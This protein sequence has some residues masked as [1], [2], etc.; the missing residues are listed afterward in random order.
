MKEI[1]IIEKLEKMLLID[2][3]S[4]IDIADLKKAI[5]K[6]EEKYSK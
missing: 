4:E 3:M 1:H 5:E 2:E 6:L